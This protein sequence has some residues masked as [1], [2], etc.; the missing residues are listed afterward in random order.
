MAD[1]LDIV[2]KVEILSDWIK[3]SYDRSFCAGEN[4]WKKNQLI[5]Q[6]EIDISNKIIQSKKVV[7][8]FYGY[9]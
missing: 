2:I 4:L 5:V 6:N 3:E 1:K 8:D 7:H 9:C